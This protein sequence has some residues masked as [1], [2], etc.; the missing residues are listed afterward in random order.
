MFS[1]WKFFGYILHV[2]EAICTLCL[3]QSVSLP[4]IYIL[5]KIIRQSAI[6]HMCINLACFTHNLP[7]RTPPMKRYIF[8]MKYSFSGHMK[9]FQKN[10]F[11]MRF[12]MITST[13]RNHPFIK[14]SS[15][16]SFRKTYDLWLLTER[17]MGWK[18][19]WKT[20]EP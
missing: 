4:K 2:L 16:C 1:F 9:Y 18:W 12:W 5:C 14:A 20:W 11:V 13:W 10:I 8:F 15:S 3:I 7:I 6:K 19:K 17:F